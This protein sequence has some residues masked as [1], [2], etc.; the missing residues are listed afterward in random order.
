MIR[1]YRLTNTDADQL[2]LELKELEETILRLNEL[3]ENEQIRS[4]FIKSKLREFKKLFGHERLS[5]ISSEDDK[6]Q[7]DDS[8][9]IE[10]RDMIIIATRDGYI[11]SISKQT[12]SSV[13]YN[14]I[15]VKEGDIP[16]CQ[17]NSNQRDKVISFN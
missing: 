9:T 12:Y 2:L 7:I 3:I 17:F 15:K 14:E 4:N 11:K 16:V 1:L 13:E 8:D 10:D 6:I 5:E